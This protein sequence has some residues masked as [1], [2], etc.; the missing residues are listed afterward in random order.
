MVDQGV[1]NHG[2]GST[3]TAAKGWDLGGSLAVEGRAVA[4]VHEDATDL[5]SLLMSLGNNQGQIPSDHGKEQDR[6]R[7]SMSLFRRATPVTCLKSSHFP[8][9]VQKSDE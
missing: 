2:G 9:W 5:Q 6:Q 3:R 4:D 7:Q 8:L 1:G